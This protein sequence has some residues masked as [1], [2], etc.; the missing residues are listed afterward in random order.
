MGA[1]RPS[2]PQRTRSTTPRDGLNQSVSVGIRIS[3]RGGTWPTTR[4]HRGGR[5]LCP[6]ARVSRPT[7]C[8]PGGAAVSRKG[9]T[10]HKRQNR[11][12]TPPVLL[13]RSSSEGKYR[14]DR[15]W[16]IRMAADRVRESNRKPI[17]KTH[18]RTDGKMPSA[19]VRMYWCNL[20]L[21]GHHESKAWTS[22][23]V[24]VQPF[25]TQ[26]NLLRAL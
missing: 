15:G 20:F 2:W 3:P 21:Q 11:K 7:I 6:R 4:T 18:R 13:R 17:S 9:L 26:A 23:G 12:N 25:A 10:D 24:H 22:G 5:L 1:R 14:L 16:P 8:R 19:K